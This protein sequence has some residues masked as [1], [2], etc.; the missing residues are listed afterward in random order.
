VFQSF[1]LLPLLSA[2]EN[3][4]MP[5][6]IAGEKIDR[7]CLELLLINVGLQDRR[8][9]RPSGLSG[10]QLQHVALARAPMTKLAMIFADEPTVREAGR[11]TAPE[12]LDVL[13]APH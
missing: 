6:L 2:E 9:H 13:K 8:H 5:L 4:V 3:I 1:N 10:G 12:I 7:D 11:L